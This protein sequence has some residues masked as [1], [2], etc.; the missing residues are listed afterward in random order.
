MTQNDVLM[1]TF[2][3]LAQLFGD[4]CLACHVIQLLHQ[5]L[6]T[7][8]VYPVTGLTDQSPLM[9]A[10]YDGRPCRIQKLCLQLSHLLLK[11]VR[12]IADSNNI[13][14]SVHIFHG[15]TFALTIT[16]YFSSS[17]RANSR[18]A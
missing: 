9:I 18:R 10:R 5:R 12:R 8:A 6:N 3:I 1:S 17:V 4:E 2:L 13:L 7:Q 14:F 16:A 11:S 15:L